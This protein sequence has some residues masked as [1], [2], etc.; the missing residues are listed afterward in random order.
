MKEDGAYVQTI[1]GC[2]E[3][4]ARSVVNQP[5][6]LFLLAWY[7]VLRAW[8]LSLNFAAGDGIVS[9]IGMYGWYYYALLEKG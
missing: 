9:L 3:T 1:A 6:T 7:G 2:A 4:I 8:P 5:A